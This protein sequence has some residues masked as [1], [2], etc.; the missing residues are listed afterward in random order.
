MSFRN[1]RKFV[2]FAQSR[3][4]RCVIAWPVVSANAGVGE[5]EGRVFS[6][7]VSDRYFHLSHGI[8]RSGDVGAE[9]PKA[10]GSSLLLQLTTCLALHALQLS[11]DLPS[12]SPALLPCLF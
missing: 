3:P 2:P 9:Q 6:R 5:R 12:Q 10:V 11:G 4:A 1:L 8:G 7:L